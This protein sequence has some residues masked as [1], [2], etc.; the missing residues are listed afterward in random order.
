MAGCVF[1]F[2]ANRKEQ[3]LCIGSCELD[4][5]DLLLRSNDYIYLCIGGSGTG[6]P[7]D[8]DFVCDFEGPIKRGRSGDVFQFGELRLRLL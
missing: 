8:Y 6:D 3:E 4:S 2:P 1:L 5:P 7:H